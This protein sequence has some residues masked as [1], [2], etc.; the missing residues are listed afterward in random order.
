MKPN[1]EFVPNFNSSFHS[2]RLEQSCFEF[3][4]HYHPEYEITFVER[5]SGKRLVGDNISTFKKNDLVFI[6]SNIPH[7]Y[8]S[9]PGPHGIRALGIQFSGHLMPESIRMKEEFFYINRL[10]NKN[11]AIRFTTSVAKEMSSEIRAIVEGQGID[12]FTRL[13]NLLDRMGRSRKVRSLTSNV[14]LQDKSL[15]QDSTLG[16]SIRYVHDYYDKVL[17]LDHVAMVTNMT[18]TS[19]CR[20][21]KN[22]TGTTFTDYV[23]NVRIGHVCRELLESDESISYIAFNNGFNSLSYFNRVFTKKKN[24]SP[25]EY[26]RRIGR[27]A[28][29]IM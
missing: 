26:R 9:V 15:Q 16:I 13:L 12:R 23:N 3:I 14:Y 8:E 11:Q 18:K 2:Y 21:F 25:S 5:G 6:G 19:F 27:H 24:L 20:F 7:A 28:S 17:S 10:L 29:V 4:W 1:F 22:K